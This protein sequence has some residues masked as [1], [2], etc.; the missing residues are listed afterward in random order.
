MKETIADQ[1]LGE[2]NR[3]ARDERQG[4]AIAR[5]TFNPLRGA[6]LRQRLRNFSVDA[7]TYIGALGGPLPY[8]VRLREID[9]LTE[10]HVE[11]LEA[12]YD[13]TPPE[14]WRRV[15]ERWDFFEVNDLIE[16]HNRYF[17]IESRLPMDP[18]TGDFA[19]IGGRPY[20]RRPLDAD[21]I[22]ERFPASAAA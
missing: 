5:D 2:L 20:R 10:E 15:A 11:R 9:R 21:W 4:R 7:S 16:R 19:T 8:M 22:L 13:V 12:A 6:P 1:V 3:T 18:R 14:R 17:P